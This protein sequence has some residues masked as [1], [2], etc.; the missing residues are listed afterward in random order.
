MGLRPGVSDTFGLKD[1][2]KKVCC[3]ELRGGV[4]SQRWNRSGGVGFMTC[5]EY[6]RILNSKLAG[7]GKRLLVFARLERPC[8]RHVFHSCDFFFGRWEIE[9]TTMTE[10]VLVRALRDQALVC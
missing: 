2:L 10:R 1:A 4:R 8:P 3:G 6:Y 9:I 5:I 7:L